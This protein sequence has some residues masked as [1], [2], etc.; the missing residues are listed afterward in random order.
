MTARGSGRVQVALDGEQVGT[1]SFHSESWAAEGIAGLSQTAVFSFGSDGTD[2]PT[3]AAGGYVDGESLAALN[4][5]GLCFAD[6]LQQNDA[7][8]ALAKIGG[9]I[10]T[11]PTGTNVNNLAVLL[12]ARGRTAIFS[13]IF[14]F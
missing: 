14:S 10:M 6:I 2:G 8:P 5:A 13:Q 7:Y 9:W 3:D 4:D 12:L 1:L 11:S